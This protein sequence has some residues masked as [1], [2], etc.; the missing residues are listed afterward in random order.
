MKQI[1]QKLLR[2]ANFNEN[3]YILAYLTKAT[4]PEN[5][6]GELLDIF[7]CTQVIPHHTLNKLVVS[8]L[9]TYNV[10]H[11]RIIVVKGFEL[12]DKAKFTETKD[13]NSNTSLDSVNHVIEI[14][15]FT[16]PLFFSP[17]VLREIFLDPSPSCL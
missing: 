1:I 9:N 6:K 14:F 5:K 17:L 3:F 11:L 8:R 12:T 15:E 7:C 4:K 13:Y 16:Y 2:T 10:N